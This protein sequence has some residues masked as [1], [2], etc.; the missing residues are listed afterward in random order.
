M[1]KKFKITLILATIVILEYTV[2][3]R[4]LLFDIFD[5]CFY[6]LAGFYAELS[7]V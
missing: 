1:K 5:D 4:E 6:A 3:I 2:I 7:L